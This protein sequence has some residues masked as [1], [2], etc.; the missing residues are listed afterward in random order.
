[1]QDLRQ[2]GSAEL[3]LQIF[4][5]EGLYNIRHDDGLMA[6]I[7]EMYIY[8]LEQLEELVQDLEED[9]DND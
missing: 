6:I 7:D 8:T 1:M 2:Y 5:I 9:Q 3:A 4:N